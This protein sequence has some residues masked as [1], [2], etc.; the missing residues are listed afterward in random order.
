MPILAIVI[1]AFVLV[2]WGV[3]SESL[4]VEF[5]YAVALL[6]LISSVIILLLW[7]CRDEFFRNAKRAIHLGSRK[8]LSVETS[9]L[10]AELRYL[11]YEIEQG[12]YAEEFGP[13][14]AI[15][16]D[17]VHLARTYCE[18]GDVTSGWKSLLRA[19][20]YC[21]Y[22]EGADEH[23]VKVRA[24]ETLC[25]SRRKLSNGRLDAVKAYLQESESPCKV[26]KKIS[27]SELFAAKRI[28]VEYNEIKQDRLA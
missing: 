8:S 5:V 18:D 13:H 20:L 3:V 23:V 4:S 1:V 22:L 17:L 25:E 19:K 28:L 15:C 10:E 11:E 9:S 12:P 14:I 21:M 27:Y 2:A 16:E 6:I 26:K 7:F 24:I